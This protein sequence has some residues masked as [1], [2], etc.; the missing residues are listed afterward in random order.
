MERFKK[1]KKKGRK[2]PKNKET[3]K[4]QNIAIVYSTSHKG[5]R[6]AHFHIT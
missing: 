3:K 2:T 4:P 6:P 1:K 5:A